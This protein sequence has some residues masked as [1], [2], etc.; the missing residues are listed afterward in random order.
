MLGNGVDHDPR[1]A[2][3]HLQQF[4]QASAGSVLKAWLEYFDSN[5]DQRISKAEFSKGLRELGYSGDAL[6]IFQIL[7]DDG[8]NELTLDEVDP[9]Q[10]RNW[11]QFRSFCTA[12]FSSTE[13]MIQQLAS[14]AAGEE[15]APEK[16]VMQK[17]KTAELERKKTAPVV[18]QIDRQQLCEGMRK[19][20]WPLG[21]SDLNYIFDALM[22]DATGTITSTSERLGWLTIE[23]ERIAKK[24][25]ALHRAK[26]LQVAKARSVV[27]PKARGKMFHDFKEFLKKKH[28]NLIRAWRK[29]LSPNDSMVLPKVAFLKAAANLGFAKESKELWKALDKDD[30]GSASIDELDPRNAEILAHFKVWIDKVFGNVAAAFAVI[31]ADNTKRIT[32]DEFDGALRRYNF[33]RPTALL[34]SQLDKDG[35]KKLEIDDLLFLDKWKPLDFLLVPPNYDAMEE[36]RR[37]L[38]TYSGRFIKAWRNL[39]DKD[40]TNRCNWYEFQDACAFLGYK[41]DISGAWRAFDEDLSGYISLREIDEDSSQTLLSFRKWACQEFGGVKSLFG[42]FDAD[43]SGTL[44]FQEFRAACRVYGYEGSTKILFAALDCD[45]GTGGPGQGQL[46]MKE[47]D[48]LDEWDLEDEEE[49]ADED[50]EEDAP[51]PVKTTNA[52]TEKQR[53]YELARELNIVEPTVTARGWPGGDDPMRVFRIIQRNRDLASRSQMATPFRSSGL[54]KEGLSPSQFLA[55]LPGSPRN[56]RALQRPVSNEFS[57]YGQD[58]MSPLHKMEASTIQ[59]FMASADFAGESQSRKDYGHWLVQKVGAPSSWAAIKER[60]D[61]QESSLL[62]EKNATPSSQ[63]RQ[64]SRG[65]GVGLQ[66]PTLDRLLHSPRVGPSSLSATGRNRRAAGVYDGRAP[67]NFSASL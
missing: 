48:F 11:K 37:K 34:F 43:G 10:A 32:L 56:A 20:G 27:S 29:S 24:T 63:P 33:P 3:E 60:G 59:S 51:T 12:L 42:V 64:G 36:V 50:V 38:L 7:D 28:G 1:Q 22:D 57:N 54:K 61:S 17:K 8:S 52:M 18:T 25:R 4:L 21:F 15:Q 65:Q 66:K 67:L 30:S 49:Y 46:S 13:D 41:G 45:Q 26:T 35:N 16:P 5:N 31:D 9:K 44:S 40:A 19:L 2:V 58:W 62:L 6:K 14:A 53:K 39:L 47:I 55:P 23:H